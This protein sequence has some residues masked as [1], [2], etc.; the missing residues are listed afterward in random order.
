[1][2]RLAALLVAL[3]A[4]PATPAFAIDKVYL[5]HHWVPEAEHCGFFQAKATGLYEQAGLDVEL[6]PG[7]PN[8]NMPLLVASGELDMG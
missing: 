4:L 8:V 3:A 7:N 2:V 1:M 5:G 6:R